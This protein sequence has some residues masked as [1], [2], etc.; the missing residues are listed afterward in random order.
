MKNLL[1]FFITQ[2]FMLPLQ[3]Q[4]FVLGNDRMNIAYLGVDNPIS[5]AV[6]NCKCKDIVLKVKNGTV[7]GQNCKYVFKGIDVGV[8]HITVYKKIGKQ[9]KI[10]GDY[11]FRVKRIPPPVFKIGPYGGTYTYERKA[12]KT[13]LANQQFARAELEELDINARFPIDSFY[14]KIFH[15]DSG[16]SEMLTNK[17]GEINQQILDAFSKLKKDDVLFFHAIFAKGPD[18]LQ[19]Q[20][21]PLILIVDD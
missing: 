15:A 21:T 1:L 9:L 18:N 8:A 16:K 20:L 19:W 13:I 3:A 11:P 10:I 14:V 7:Q 5:V 4:T 17:T 2:I 6:E 12:N